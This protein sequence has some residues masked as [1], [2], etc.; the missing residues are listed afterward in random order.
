MVTMLS[1]LITY[2]LSLITSLPLG[3]V[4]GGWETFLIIVVAVLPAL[5][6]GYYLWYIDSKREPAVWLIGSVLLGALVCLPVVYLKGI[7]SSLLFSPAGV[8]VSLFESVVD[9][10]CLEAVLEEV[11]KFVAFFL[12]VFRNRY[13]D[14]HYDGIIYAACVGLGFA[15]VENVFYLF[16]QPGWELLP[17]LRAILSVLGHSAYAVLMGYYY[18]LYRFVSRTRLNLIFTLLIPI[19]VH[20]VFNTLLLPF[21]GGLSMFLFFAFCIFIHRTCK[22]K[23]AIHLANDIGFMNENYRI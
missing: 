14:E 23:I 5:L 11:F 9:T 13:F 3:G 21:W 6:L 1:S 12:V 22:K 10:F 8:P 17:V 20:A 19:L 16:N 2:C 7:F 18:S 4:G 15:A